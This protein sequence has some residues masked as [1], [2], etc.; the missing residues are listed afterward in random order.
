MSDVK[1]KIRHA[2]RGNEKSIDLSNM[3]LTDIPT[4]LLNLP[5]IET[6]NLSNNKLIS[7]RRIEQL[8]NLREII[9]SNNNISSLHQELSDVYGLETIVLVGNPI[10][11]A[12]PMLANIDKNEELVTQALDSYFNGG[13]ASLPPSAMGVSRTVNNDQ[14]S[15]SSTLPYGSTAFSAGK[16]SNTNPMGGSMGRQYTGGVAATAASNTRMQAAAASSNAYGYS[17]AAAG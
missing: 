16:V 8:S 15:K 5:F 1:L 17:G 2:K 3:G 7:L 14:E 13:G 12:N 6:V 4:D 10:V 11:N 9:A